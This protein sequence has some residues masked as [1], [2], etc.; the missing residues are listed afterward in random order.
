MNI[1]PLIKMANE[2]STFFATEGGE[3]HGAELMATHLRRYWEQRMRREIIAH[4]R[5]GGGGL[6]ELS[7][8]SVGMLANDAAP[9][10]DPETGGDAG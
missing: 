6:N 4:Y 1:D 5:R 3:E 10:P 9:E 7:L 8:K 2:M